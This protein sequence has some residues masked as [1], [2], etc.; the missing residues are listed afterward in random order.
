MASSVAT[1]VKVADVTVTATTTTTTTTATSTPPAAAATSINGTAETYTYFAIGSMINNTSLSL[2][3]LKPS[4]SAPAVVKDWEL[5]FMGEGG[6]S[7]DHTIIIFTISY[8]RANKC[9]CVCLCVVV[10]YGHNRA[11]GRWSYSWCI[12]YNDQS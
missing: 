9:V 1:E 8:A 4:W 3:G 11:K 7:I 5:R 2:R 6:N 12:T 10:R